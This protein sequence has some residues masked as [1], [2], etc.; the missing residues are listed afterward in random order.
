VSSDRTKLTNQQDGGEAVLEA[1]RNL[2]VD[3]VIS[4]PGSEWPPIWEALARQKTAGLSGPTYMDCGHETLAVGVA[5]G[6]GTVG[7]G[8]LVFVRGRLVGRTALCGAAS[9]TGGLAGPGWFDRA[10]ILKPNRSASRIKVKP[11]SDM[12]M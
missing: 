10:A 1:C 5:V 2:H 4:S 6:A 9:A 8:E 12:K 11:A 7:A 3:Y